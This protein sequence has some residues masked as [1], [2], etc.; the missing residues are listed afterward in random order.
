[1]KKVLCLMAC[2][3]V[4]MIMKTSAQVNSVE[5]G[6]NRVQYQNFKWKYYQTENFNSYFSQNG[7]ALGK[8]VAQIAE[9]ELPGLEEFVEYGLQRRANI[10]IYNSFDEMQQSNIGLGID[11]Q[12]TGGV[13]KLVNNKMI[14]YFD[15]NH[16]N[17]RLQ[18]RQGIA[19]ILVENVLF[20]DDL[21]EFAANQALLDLPKWLTDGY[22]AYA[23]QNWSPEL[24][25]DLRAV[26][27]GGLYN[28]F[29]QFAYEKPDLAGHAFWY[30]I[31]NKYGKNKT[32]YL[33]YLAR[34][35]RNLNNASMKVANKKFKKILE[36]FML[37]IPLQ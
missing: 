36:D 22:I 18:I 20:G 31:A 10:V 35:Y 28:N 1:M 24:D 14:V 3:P 4:F 34:I 15:A 8:Y 13:T 27:L 23:A 33:L 17:L 30:Y 11:W 12:N 26:M 16:D 9:Q 7:L 19:R 21:G 32:T 37:E 6:K 29:Y 2:F 5:F 25:D